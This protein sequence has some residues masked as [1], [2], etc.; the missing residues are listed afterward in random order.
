[1]SA[2]P[3]LAEQENVRLRMALETIFR[4]VVFNMLATSVDQAAT[5]RWIQCHVKSIYCDKV[6]SDED[7]AEQD[8]MATTRRA[9]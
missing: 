8:A 1:M 6:D 7:T 9:T 4:E 3:S 2:V 5:L